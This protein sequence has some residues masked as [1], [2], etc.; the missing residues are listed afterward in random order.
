M[1]HEAVDDREIV[2]RQLGRQPRAFRR[3]V[4]RC[5]FGRPAV[6]EQAP[7]DEDGRPS[8]TQYYVT[9]R[10]L[11]AAISRLEA[12]G[13]VDRWTRAAVEDQELGRSLEQAQ[14]QQ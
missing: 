13:G 4:V 7:F 6:T 10:S 9:S 5:P 14:A 2:A 8:P 12:A 1:D 11:G 3:V